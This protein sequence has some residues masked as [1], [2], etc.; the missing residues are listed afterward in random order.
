M[1]YMHPAGEKLKEDATV[2]NTKSWRES[3]AWEGAMMRFIMTCVG[4]S[5]VP[6]VQ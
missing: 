6:P 4:V 3:P 1:L 2:N 5:N